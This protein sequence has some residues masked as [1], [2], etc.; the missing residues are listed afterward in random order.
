MGPTEVVC[1]AWKVGSWQCPVHCDAVD[2][3]IEVHDGN[4]CRI[5][6]E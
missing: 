6:D 4:H 1:I 2:A 5:A 3:D